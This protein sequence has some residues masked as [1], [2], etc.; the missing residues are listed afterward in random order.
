MISVRDGGHE[1]LEYIK[2][3]RLPFSLHHST[4]ANPLSSTNLPYQV[5]HSPPTML[6]TTT[7]TAVFGTLLSLASAAPSSLNPRQG[8]FYAVGQL[9]SGGGC[10]NLIFA[11]PIFTSNACTPLDRNNNVPDIT[12]YRTSSVAAGCSGK[13]LEPMGKDSD[14]NRD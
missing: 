7:L 5:P 9:Y 1:Q 10:T 12:S 8:S 11:D 6:S 13:Y 3:P 2:E 14:E 4:T